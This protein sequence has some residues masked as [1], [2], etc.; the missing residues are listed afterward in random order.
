MAIK[1]PILQMAKAISKA[2]TS[3]KPSPEMQQ[4]SEAMSS[5]P[6]LACQ[7]IELIFSHTEKKHSAGR[8]LEALAHMLTAA[9]EVER[10]RAESRGAPSTSL[11][12]QL[13][14]QASLLARRQEASPLAI[15]AV[16]GAFSR[17]KVPLG[18]D[19]EEILERRFNSV[20][21]GP[22]QAAQAEL[23]ER[24]DEIASSLGNNPFLVHEQL[25]ELLGPLP[26]HAQPAIIGALPFMK[27]GA[28]REA[29][30]GW[31]LD[32]DDTVFRTVSESML[33]A[34][35][36]GL[37]SANSIGRMIH[38][39]TWIAE[40]RR[41]AV[42]SIIRKA[43]QT[44]AAPPAAARALSHEI[45]IT[46]PDGAG[47]Q[48]I[49]I[50]LRQRKSGSFANILVKHGFGIR[51]A[52]ISPDMSQAE[53]EG[54]M[55]VIFAETDAYEVSLESLKTVIRHG[56]AITIN[57]G[58]HIP[59]ELV[60]I[61]DTL[62]LD[63]VTPEF[64]DAAKLIGLIMS[65]AAMSGATDPA[66]RKA[67]AA[68]R[69]WPG[70]IRMFETWFAD[71]SDAQISAIPAGSRASRERYVLKEAI[72]PR[73]ARWGELLAWSAFVIFEEDCGLAC[74]MAMNAEL[75]LGGKPLEDLPLAVW[76]AKATLAASK[77]R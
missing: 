3:A 53:A 28:L 56:L 59:F 13:R 31:L 7:V 25:R 35:G 27:H 43:R 14:Q 50:R 44:G 12:D 77:W 33:Q 67:I 57:S 20:P 21:P 18:G 34:A 37:V 75:M 9:L 23:E 30:A 48:S 73:R 52:W 64:L 60:R 16:A 42:D 65:D 55:D 46:A 40:D 70:R 5:D 15:D 62:G 71:L 38:I 19:L 22:S 8:I 1:P 39:R 32:R 6:S 29:A 45:I 66:L 26:P 58:G 68:S 63:P 36:Q 10:W 41:A 2:M 54:F 17:A 51:E 4:V 24:L 61:L 74:D 11:I 76:I 72:G 47:A 49:H 69:H